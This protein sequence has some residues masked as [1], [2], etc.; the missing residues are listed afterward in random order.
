MIEMMHVGSI[1]EARQ[2]VTE[3]IGAMG[4]ATAEA[5][6]MQVTQETL[7]EVD[8]ETMHGRGEGPGWCVGGN[9]GGST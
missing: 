1:E 7:Q 3:T 4:R 2:Q 5:A 6:V 8:E 9:A